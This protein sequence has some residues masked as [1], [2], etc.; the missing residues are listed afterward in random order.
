MQF[1]KF[2]TAAAAAGLLAAGVPAQAAI[3][4]ATAVDNATVFNTVVVQD[5]SLGGGV[6]NARYLPPV[7][8]TD[9]SGVVNLWFRD[10]TG[11]VRS[12]CTGS[13]LNSRTILSAGH[14]VSTGTNAISWSSFT[15]RFRNADGS[16]TEVNG[17]GFKVQDGYSG[18]VVEE[19]DVAV[20]TL[21]SDAPA[22]ARTYSLFN[23]D[24]LQVFNMAGYGRIG[25]GLTGDSVNSGQFN[26]GLNTLRGG[27]NRFETTG[28][29]GAIYATALN[30]NPSAFGGIL[31]GDMDRDGL[32]THQTNFMCATLGFCDLGEDLDETAVGR[33]D[34]GGAAFTTGWEVLGVASFAQSTNGS[35]VGQYGTSFGYACVAN[36]ALNA[37]CLAN[38]Q[39]VM[40]NLY[41][42]PEPASFALLGAGLVGFA[43]TRRRRVAR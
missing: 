4:G 35:T 34:S 16:V 33:G 31:R 25:D 12:G 30:A 29:D 18:A 7:T 42:I 37:A 41:R 10:A 24:P 38:Y 11:T 21:A 27:I 1:S 22:T 17:S 40:A 39:F 3:V 13:L 9:Y 32:T 36:Y 14:C 5:T 2:A 28:R 19:Q 6:N 20:L 8:D 43:A 15:A 26:A 23:G